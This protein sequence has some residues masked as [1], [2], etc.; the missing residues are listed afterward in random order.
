MARGETG[1]AFSCAS[2]ARRVRHLFPAPC[3]QRDSGRYGV[4]W[5]LSLACE[6]NRGGDCDCVSAAQI[7][8]SAARARA[9]SGAS[10]HPDHCRR[11]VFFILG[12]VRIYCGRLVTA[13]APENGITLRHPGQIQ[14]RT[15]PATM[16][17]GA[18]SLG[19]LVDVNPYE[20]PR[21]PP[22]PP[23]QPLPGRADLRRAAAHVTCFVFLTIVAVWG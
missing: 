19:E 21:V 2:G 17:P 16:P 23:P 4:V 10:V 12:M 9:F 5:Q 22:S 7:C 15:L 20:S 1:G 8:A 13:P 18:K 3:P 11:R 14:I 6:D